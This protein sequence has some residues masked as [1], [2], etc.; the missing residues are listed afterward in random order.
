MSLEFKGGMSNETKLE[1]SERKRYIEYL[2]SLGLNFLDTLYDRRLYGLINTSCEIVAPTAE[3]SEFGDYAPG[4]PGLSFVASAFDSFREFYFKIAS[5]TDLGIP[6]LISDLQPS[7]SY[8]DF[9]EGYARYELVTSNLLLDKLEEDPLV[10][11][12]D[13]EEFLVKINKLIFNPFFSDYRLTKSGYALS[14]DSSVHH[15]GLYI[16]LAIGL[17]AQTDLLKGEF[18]QDEN[19]KCFVEFANEF[20]FLV[21]ANLPW[22]LAADLESPIMQQN[23][24]NGRPKDKFDDFYDDIYTLKV[25][26]DDY[27]AL[28]SFYEK[29]FI[30]SL[31]RAEVPSLPQLTPL[32][33][34]RW[35]EVLLLNRF[36]ELGLMK[37]EVK[38][39]Y[40]FEILQKTIDRYNR[41]GLLSTSGAVGFLNSFA[42][43]ELKKTLEG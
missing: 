5:E 36:R 30:E 41:Y 11:I 26:Y 15:T 10:N 34:E 23:I 7:K 22:R 29:L 27:W 20:G 9:D 19:F 38:T 4:V 3:L 33:E 1:Y 17:P 21:D 16:N 14:R 31:R 12:K 6:S 18:A 43:S 25:A 35:L 39:E 42:A 13:F 24:L 32:S 2:R 28:K 40:F 37:N 8:V